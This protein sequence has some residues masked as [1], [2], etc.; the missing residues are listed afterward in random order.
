MKDTTERDTQHKKPYV[1]PTLTRVK[2]TEAEVVL[3]HCKGSTGSPPNSK[4][5]NFPCAVCGAS[6]GS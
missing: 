2:L 4:S 1:K 3:G 6:L 5:P